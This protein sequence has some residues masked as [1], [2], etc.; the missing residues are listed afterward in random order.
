MLK[1]TLLAL[2]LF[3]APAGFLMSNS[4]GQRS[5]TGVAYFRQ[6]TT[7]LATYSYPGGTQAWKVKVLLPHQ[8]RTAGYGGVGC[9]YVTNVE[10]ECFGTYV[11]PLGRI[12]VLGDI[13]RRDK[14]TLAI[15][16]GT[17]VYQNASGVAVFTSS[18]A[19][20]YLS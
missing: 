9:V 15:I 7:S 8:D 13:M 1:T 10:R 2:A 3:L 19:T 20:F 17:G 6:V 5:V 12:K 4:S 14:Y 16:G 18:L 11:L